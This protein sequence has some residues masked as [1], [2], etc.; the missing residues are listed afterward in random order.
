MNTKIGVLL[1]GLSFAAIGCTTTS[2]AVYN[3][4]T[5]S[6]LLGGHIFGEEVGSKNDAIPENEWL[7]VTEGVGYMRYED[8][9]RLLTTELYRLD[10]SAIEFLL[11][12]DPENAVSVS[13]WRDKYKDAILIVNG[14][15]FAE[16]FEPTGM[17]IDEGVVG[18]AA[19]S[20]EKSALLELA[21]TPQIHDTQDGAPNLSLIE[22]GLQ[23]YP[24]LIRD[25]ELALGQDSGKV[26]QRTFM[27][28]D[29]QGN[30]YI[31]VIP[32]NF[33]TLHEMMLSLNAL[34]V[35]WKHVLNLDGAGSTGL[36]AEAE[37]HH[38]MINSVTPVPHVIVVRSN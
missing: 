25:G 7:A 28:T 10:P 32:Y 37:N 33:V 6:D 17:L 18:D 8:N 16:N 15:Y 3:E 2:T 36:S 21:P 26:A 34:D 22:E 12:N 30:L 13:E 1:I 35:E 23:S 27:G 4:D 38:N 14:S 20:Y 29:V 19:Y 9:T 31:G 11:V 24:V 5:S